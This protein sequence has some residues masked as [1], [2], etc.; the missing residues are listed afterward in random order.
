MQD[1]NRTRSALMPVWATHWTHCLFVPACTAHE[2]GALLSVCIW[3]A[4][5]GRFALMLV[6]QRSPESSSSSCRGIGSWNMLSS[7][8]LCL[9]KEEPIIKTEHLFNRCSEFWRDFDLR[10]SK[11]HG[12]KIWRSK[13]FVHTAKLCCVTLY[14]YWL[15]VHYTPDVCVNALLDG[16]LHFPT[17][18]LVVFLLHRIT[19]SHK[20]EVQRSHLLEFTAESP[21]KDRSTRMRAC[22][23]HTF[24]AWYD[25]DTVW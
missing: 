20:V 4:P 25:G 8:D 6:L 13:D 16:G 10:S 11:D 17:A 21:H 14:D 19:F 24:S 2:A 22:V 23:L 15:Y 5:V 12:L 9:I 7:V 1:S 18:V 3:V